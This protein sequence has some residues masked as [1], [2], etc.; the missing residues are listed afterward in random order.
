LGLR[1]LYATFLSDTPY[2]YIYDGKEELKD[3]ESV[4]SGKFQD[5]YHIFDMCDLIVTNPPFSENSVEIL[6]NK[7]IG[8]DKNFIIVGPLSV[9]KKDNILS[10]IIN[11]QLNV[12]YNTIRSFN[13]PDDADYKGKQ[14]AIWLT[15][16][17]VKHSDIK[18]SSKFDPNLYVKYDNFD[19]I[20]VPTINRQSVKYIPYDYDGPMGVPISF[21]SKYSPSQFKILGKL[22]RPMLNGEELFTRL[23]IQKNG[24]LQ[25][26]KKTIYINESKINALLKALNHRQ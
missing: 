4:K 3:Y 20:H 12:G 24:S 15:N 22:E 13:V 5:N 16:L 23:I 19:A 17:P 18:L 2:L 25:E 26:S 14:T 9:V 10:Y 8:S 7:L 6:I 11:G 21:I 1:G